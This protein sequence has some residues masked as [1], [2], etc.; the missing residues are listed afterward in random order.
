MRLF[1]GRSSD[2]EAT[3]AKQE[4]T[5][6]VCTRSVTIPSTYNNPSSVDLP[7]YPIQA[8]SIRTSSAGSIGRDTPVFSPNFAPSTQAKSIL[9]EYDL[10]A[11]LIGDGFPSRDHKTMVRA[12]FLDNIYYATAKLHRHNWI[13]KSGNDKYKECKSMLFHT[14]QDS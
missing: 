1:T 11:S 12:M 13:L 14:Y 8:P 6:A 5:S 7:T 2:F 9:D 4:P 3:T 10:K